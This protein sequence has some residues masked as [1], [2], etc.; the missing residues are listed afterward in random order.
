VNLPRQ[1]RIGGAFDGDAARRWPLTIA[2][3]A[4]LR[5]YDGPGG[6]RRVIAAGA[7]RWFAQH[8][9][10][11][12]AGARFNTVGAEE[13][14]ASGGISV[15]VRSGLYLDAHVVGGGSANERGWGVAARVSF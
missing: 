15:A 7:E 4:D 10:A 14:A 12:R 6:E 9:V 2:I 1:V 11:V 13:R 3:D 5:R 8:R